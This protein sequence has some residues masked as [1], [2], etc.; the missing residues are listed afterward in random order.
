MVSF[1]KRSISEEKRLKT[2]SNLG[3][4]ISERVFSFAGKEIEVSPV[5]P[6]KPVT[7]DRFETNS[8]RKCNEDIEKVTFEAENLFKIPDENGVPS[9]DIREK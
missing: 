9:G 6:L 4:N 1:K 3:S 8:Q 5:S 2:K 7:P